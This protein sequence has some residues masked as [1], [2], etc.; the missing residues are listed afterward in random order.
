MFVSER[1]FIG[2][3]LALRGAGLKAPSRERPLYSPAR[4]E[5]RPAL[6]AIMFVC[7]FL[8]GVAPRYV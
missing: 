8:F 7:V 2:L 5:K 1:I 4:S 6:S 3:S